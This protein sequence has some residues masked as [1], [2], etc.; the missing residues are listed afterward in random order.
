M[1]NIAD[2]E[3]APISE[4]VCGIKAAVAEGEIPQIRYENYCLLYDEL[5][6]QRK[7]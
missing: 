4:P 1:K 2:S 5:K 7:Y 6:N 3:A